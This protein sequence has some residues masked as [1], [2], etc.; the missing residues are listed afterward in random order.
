MSFAAD[1]FVEDLQSYV[2]SH[3]VVE[4][5]FMK[6]NWLKRK[7]VGADFGTYCQMYL[8]DMV[9]LENEYKEDS[10]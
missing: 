9:E 7:S 10:I 5:V 8:H 2:E 3:D 6:D 4:L 1:R